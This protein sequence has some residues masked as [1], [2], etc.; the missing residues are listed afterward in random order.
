MR[1]P[2]KWAE[3]TGKTI[4]RS[5]G[6][7]DLLECLEW[8]RGLNVHVLNGLH[9]EKGC[10][11]WNVWSVVQYLSAQAERRPRERRQ[12]VL[13]G[14]VPEQWACF[15]CT[16]VFSAGAGFVSAL[17]LAHSFSS[18]LCQSLRTDWQFLLQ[19]RKIQGCHPFLQQ[20]SGR[21]PNTRCAQEMPAGGWGRRA[22]LLS[23]NLLLF[24][25]LSLN[26]EP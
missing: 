11:P 3:K 10:W 20:V 22:V 21:A 7:L 19:R 15:Y 2:L 14:T 23:L 25:V 12:K 18:C 26:N 5:P 13:R 1:R 6:T 16:C 24:Y 8:F 17:P 9:G 4:D